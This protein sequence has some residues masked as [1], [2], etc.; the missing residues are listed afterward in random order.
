M[1]KEIF[2]L[3]LLSHVIGDYYFQNESMAEQK[4]EHFSVLIKHSVIYAVACLIIIIPVFNQKLLIAAVALSASH[5]IIDSLK[6][7]YFNA[8]KKKQKIS[9]EKERNIYITDQCLHLV[10]ILIISYI[11]VL[12]KCDFNE[13]T[14]IDNIF[15]VIGISFEKAF[16]W[17]LALL[18]I[19]KPSNITIKKLLSLYKPDGENNDNNKNN[20]AGE[21]IGVLERIIILVLMSISQYSAIGLVLTAKSI[22]R[23]NKI[24]EDKKFAEYYLLGTLLSTAIAIIAYLVIF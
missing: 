9:S 16:S 2:L 5:F 3:L 4:N 17:L 18:L 13:L 14:F 24:S 22:A 8:L 11:A 19:W 1:F 7:C 23:Y 15:R 20:N 6:F 12:N 10:F 21:F